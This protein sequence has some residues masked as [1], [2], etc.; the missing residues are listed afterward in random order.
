[1]LLYLEALLLSEV[2]FSSIRKC[3][4]FF[5]PIYLSKL[6]ITR[7]LSVSVKSMNNTHG[8]ELLVQHLRL[9][10]SNGIFESNRC[11]QT[12]LHL[13]YKFVSFITLLWF[14]WRT[15]LNASV[16][17]S[18]PTCSLPHRSN[19]SF[20]NSKII[21]QPH[22]KLFLQLCLSQNNGSQYRS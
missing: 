1:M 8:T 13:F 7:R 17:W 10:L 20:S 4:L 16:S 15:Q 21:L 18:F 3:I 5:S 6:Y 9:Y 2:T 12:Y 22:L 14:Y 19:V 11:S